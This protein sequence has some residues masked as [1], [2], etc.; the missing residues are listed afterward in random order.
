MLPSEQHI[1][2][3]AV[4][5]GVAESVKLAQL[6]QSISSWMAQRAQAKSDVESTTQ[7]TTDVP[8]RIT[9]SHHLACSKPLALGLASEL[10]GD[11]CS[12][13]EEADNRSDQTLYSRT[14][15]PCHA[16][17]W[18]FSMRAGPVCS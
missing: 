11:N 18:V 15:C 8:Q 14:T 12:S 1:P 9:Y 17:N 10:L 13:Q 4:V 2:T 3:G 5:A 6:Q 16:R 7:Q